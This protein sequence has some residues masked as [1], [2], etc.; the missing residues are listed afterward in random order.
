MKNRRGEILVETIIFVVLN[1]VFIAILVLFLLRQGSGAALIEESYSKQIALLIDASK[2]GMII[3]LDLEDGFDL[4]EKNGM[5]IDEIISFE[6][7]AVTVK[8]KEDSGKSYSYFND[9]EVKWY[10]DKNENHLCVLT[11]ENRENLN[12]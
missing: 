9:V 4:A 2:P 3:K 1:L 8:L 5:N 6:N 7:N 10:R 12:V 11:I